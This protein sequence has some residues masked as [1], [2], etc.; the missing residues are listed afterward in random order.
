MAVAESGIEDPEEAKP[1]A[2]AGYSLA[3]VGSAH[4][5]APDP[6]AFA[7]ALLEAGRC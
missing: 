6:G 5:R 4:M 7:A 2:Q 3:L 1:L